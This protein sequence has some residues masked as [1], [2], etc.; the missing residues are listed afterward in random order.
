VRD[1][2]DIGCQLIPD[3]VPKFRLDFDTDIARH[4]ERNAP[5]CQFDNE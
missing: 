2:Q 5:V 3:M 4:Q 1:F